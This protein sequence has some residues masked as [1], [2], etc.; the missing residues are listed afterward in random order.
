MLEEEEDDLAGIEPMTDLEDSV[1]VL[2]RETFGVE[3]GELST[4]LS[5]DDLNF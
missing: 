4:F 1:N 5:S 2:L 3:D